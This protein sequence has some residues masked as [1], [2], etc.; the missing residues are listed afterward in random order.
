MITFTSTKE[1]PTRRGQL[2]PKWPAHVPRTYFKS[3]IVW[4]RKQG[5]PVS[6]MRVTRETTASM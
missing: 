5:R 3:L 2:P 1:A 4:P 6:N